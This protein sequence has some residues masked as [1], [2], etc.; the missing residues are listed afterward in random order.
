MFGKS[1]N[2]HYEKRKM[3]DYFKEAKQTVEV[4]ISEVRFLFHAL[5]RCK[6]EE[7]TLCDSWNSSVR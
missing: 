2:N 4:D 7:T 3:G 1:R 5:V 6:N